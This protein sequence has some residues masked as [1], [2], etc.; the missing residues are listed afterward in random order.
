MSIAARGWSGRWQ[1]LDRYGHVVDRAQAHTLVFIDETWAKTN[2][3]RASHGCF[4]KVTLR[5]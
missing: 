1:G 5:E 2:I 4:R 3:T